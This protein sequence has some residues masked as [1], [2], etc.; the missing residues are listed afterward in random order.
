MFVESLAPGWPGIPARWT[1]SAKSGVGTALSARSR[2]W[3]TISHGIL[4]EIYYPRVD[5]A[6]TRDFGLIV[7]DGAASSPRRSAIRAATSGRLAERRPGLRHRAAPAS[8]A[9]IGSRRSCVLRSAARRRPAA[10][11]VPPPHRGARRLPALCAAGAASGQSWRTQ[12][13]L[14]RRLQGRCRCSSREGAGAALAARQFRA[15]R[16]ALGGLRRRLR[17]LAGSVAAFRAALA[18]TITRATATSR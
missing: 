3:F 12:H 11:G 14:G 8:R 10:R 9:A 16:R 1:S 4:N 6:C 2:V 17:R 13:G 18:T 15:L 5:H 7:T